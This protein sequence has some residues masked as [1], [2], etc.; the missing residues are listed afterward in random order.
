MIHM[1]MVSR[2][3]RDH[4][5]IVWK[6]SQEDEERLSEALPLE[7]V[8]TPR[9]KPW[10]L[11]LLQV[12]TMNFCSF[13]ACSSDSKNDGFGINGAD[14][15]HVAVPNTLASDAVSSHLPQR[16]IKH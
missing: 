4:K 6:I 3:G 13:D 10:M 15:I 9:P 11:H 5:L 7:N 14:E 2:H 8:A 12:N 16:R 1:L